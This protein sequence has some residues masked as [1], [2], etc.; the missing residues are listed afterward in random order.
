MNN[1]DQMPNDFH[2]SLTKKHLGGQRGDTDD[3]KID[4]SAVSVQSGGIFLRGSFSKAGLYIDGNYVD[5]K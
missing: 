3:V 1:P 4:S 2:F 5:K